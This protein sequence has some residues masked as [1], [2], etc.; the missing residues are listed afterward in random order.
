MP[1]SISL[2]VSY[3]WRML[4]IQNST[5]DSYFCPFTLPSRISGG[6][7]CRVW[8]LVF[9]VFHDA[10]QAQPD[11]HA[12]GPKHDGDFIQ[13]QARGGRGQHEAHQPRDPV[14]GPHPCLSGPALT[15][16]LL[17]AGGVVFLASTARLK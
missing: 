10:L 1:A 13:R 14:P 9:Q 16:R 15:S 7:L 5:F 2:F 17:S 12:Q 3:S 8:G 11:A 6:K 4:V